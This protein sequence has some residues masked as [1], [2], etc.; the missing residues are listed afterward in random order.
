[1]HSR[2][3]IVHGPE[4]VQEYLGIDCNPAGADYRLLPEGMIGDIDRYFYC[5][6]GELVSALEAAAAYNS[7]QLGRPNRSVNV[8]DLRGESC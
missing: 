6:R 4:G 7:E 2:Y 3:F 1:M 5:I 8:L